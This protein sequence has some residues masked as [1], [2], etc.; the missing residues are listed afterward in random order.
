[1]KKLLFLMLLGLFVTKV[2]AQ[3]IY[4]QASQYAFKYVENGKWTDWTEW[5]ESDVVLSIDEDNDVI[6]VYTFNKQTYVVVKH[7]REY[8]DSSGGKQV[9]F[10]VV[11]QD[12]DKG[13]IRLRVEKNGNAQLYVEFSDIIWVYSGIKKIND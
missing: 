9:E 6:N 3:A 4:Y 5:M 11:D 13:K 2:D 1:M 10:A 7:N 12:G 8:T